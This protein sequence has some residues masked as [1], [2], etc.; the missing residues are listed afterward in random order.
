M[1]QIV[2]HN[3]IL[4]DPEGRQPVPGGLILDRDRI[5]ARLDPTDRAGGN[6]ARVDLG[7]RYLAPGFIDLHY[8]GRFAFS[9]NDAVADAAREALE[10]A[11]SLVRHGTTAY[12]AT[13]V[14]QPQDALSGQVEA[15]ARMLAD[16]PGGGARPIGLHLEGPWINSEAAG[17]QPLAGIRPCRIQE[18]RDLLGRADGWVRM[19]TLAP[20]V[21]GAPELL[22]LL[23]RRGIVASLGHSRA[24]FDQID[25]A[26]KRGAGHVTHLF[27]AMAPF[28]HR[29]PGLIGAALGDHRLS[30]DLICD[31]VHVDPRVVRLA[32]RALA[33]R[34][35]LITDRFDPPHLS[36]DPSLGMGELRNDGAAIRLADGRLAGSC[37]T[38]DAA[39]RN[40]TEFANLSLLEAVSA[41]TL[42]PA[43]LLG[44]ER[45]YGTLRPGARADL[46]VLDAEGGVLE[47]WIDGQRVHP[48]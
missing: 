18:A 35:L 4:L 34:L 43:R 7:E 3:A 21:E 29:A 23:R 28:H 11:A 30:A 6:R 38:L 14:A 41:C 22:E 2:L 27:N 44:I 9:K 48:A 42:R 37:L 15:L 16:P 19:V 31:G 45:E 33:E 39:V 17:A 20:E 25:A 13:T 36:R 10:H 8:H 12:L 24:S 46:V 32:A 47:T 1:S 5:H 40:V 26:I